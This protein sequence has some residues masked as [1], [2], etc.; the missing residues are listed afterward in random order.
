MTPADELLAQIL[1]E[2][3]RDDLRLIFADWLEENGDGERA[4][5]IR[6]QIE[7]ARLGPVGQEASDMLIGGPIQA[8]RRRERALRLGCGRR[9][10]MGHVTNQAVWSGFDDSLYAAL[11]PDYRRGFVAEITC[12]LDNWR[13]HGPTIV[14]CQPVEWVRISDREPWAADIGRFSW[15][16]DIGPLADYHEQSNVLKDIFKLLPDGI[17]GR[18][19]VCE[20]YDSPEAAHE[21]LSTACLKWAKK[22]AQP[23]ALRGAL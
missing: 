1:A 18:R 22:D 3:E 12:T 8:L 10:L 2:P 20:V 11:R 6:V 19:L 9:T 7:L 16:L 13:T 21:A 5:F 15:W 23:A 14:R 17:R 4:E